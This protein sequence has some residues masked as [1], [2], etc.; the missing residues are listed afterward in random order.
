ME[1]GVKTR[2]QIIH[3]ERHEKFIDY[4]VYSMYNGYCECI[5]C[6]GGLVFKGKTKI[7]HSQSVKRKLFLE[8]CF[9]EF[10]IQICTCSKCTS[11]G[12]IW[13]TSG[14]FVYN[15]DIETHQII[16]R[17]IK[18]PY[19]KGMYGKFYIVSKMS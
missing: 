16:F 12:H 4:M 5:L 3:K 1:H 8:H 2:T 6:I 18:Y 19:D 9:W 14:Y 10:I 17:S 11:M 13:L 7:C 15:L